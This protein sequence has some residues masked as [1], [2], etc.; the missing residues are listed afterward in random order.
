MCHPVLGSGDCVA[1]CCDGCW[2]IKQMIIK[3]CPR[4]SDDKSVHML[5]CGGWVSNLSRF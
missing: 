5:L 3:D 2:A 4:A 1:S